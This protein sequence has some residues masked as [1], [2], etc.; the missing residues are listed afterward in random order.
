MRFSERFKH[1]SPAVLKRRRMEYAVLRR[2]CL[3][4]IAAGYTLSLHN[5]EDWCVKKVKT[6]KEVL[7][8][9]F[10]VDEERLYVFDGDKRLGGVFLVYGNDGYDV[11]CDYHTSLEPLMEKGTH[12]LEDRLAEVA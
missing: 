2:F 8:A 10:S 5:G 3:D 1:L 7:D 4:A 12:Q 11:I 9:A 6:A